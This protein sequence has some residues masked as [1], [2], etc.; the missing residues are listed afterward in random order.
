MQ[1]YEIEQCIDIT[2]N[3][4]QFPGALFFKDPVLTKDFPDYY[5][6][7]K[8]PS[9]LNTI[10]QKLKDH[11]YSKIDQWEKDIKLI[12]SNTELYHG[13]DSYL[14]RIAHHMDKHFQKLKKTI[15]MMKI[16]GWMKCL[17]LWRDKLDRYLTNPPSNLNFIPVINPYKENYQQFSTKELDCFVEATKQMNLFN[18]KQNPEVTKIFAKIIQSDPNNNL[19]EDGVVN[20]DALS[21]K[22]LHLL[23]DYIKK[24]FEV[25]HLKYPTT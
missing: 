21:P 18:N 3:L 22:T 7:I 13:K 25:N 6:K 15:G 11:K 24:Y 14:C 8:T 20:V 5:N 1:E 17:Y 16:S 9:D 23:R 12:W 4:I 10:L 2:K 19:E